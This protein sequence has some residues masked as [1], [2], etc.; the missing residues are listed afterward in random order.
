MNIDYEKLAS[1]YYTAKN[2]SIAEAAKVLKKAPS[3]VSRHLEIL[4]ERWNEKLIIRGSKKI[5]LTETGKA[6]FG[7]IH[8]TISS[9]AKEFEKVIGEEKNS[10]N[11]LRIM[12]TTG[13]IGVWIVRKVILLRKEFPELDIQVLTTNYDFDLD[14]ARADVGILPKQPFKGLSQ[15]KI[16]TLHPQLYASPEYLKKYGTPKSLND[17]KN[18]RLISYYAYYEERIGNVDWHIAYS[19]KGSCM[20]INSGFLL[21]EAARQGAGII[22]LAE[23]FEY[24]KNSN[25]VQILTEAKKP[26]FDIFYVTRSDVPLTKAQKRFRELLKEV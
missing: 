14:S 11:K 9:F 15:K 16:R 3:T 19:E 18:H 17:L 22:S 2:G 4:E 6:L 7:L 23:E 20:S 25:L 13:I 5:E 21:F 24:F 12:T 10:P 1:F 26:V 8:K